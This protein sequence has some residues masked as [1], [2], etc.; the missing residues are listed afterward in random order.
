[1]NDLAKEYFDSLGLTIRAIQ[2]D[3]FIMEDFT[4]VKRYSR[5]NIETWG[6]NITET[7][8]GYFCIFDTT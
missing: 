3:E 1:M 2:G 7:T 5:E 8:V 4:S 6:G